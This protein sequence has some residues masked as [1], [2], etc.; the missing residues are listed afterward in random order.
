MLALTF[1]GLKSIYAFGSLS[2][3]AEKIHSA[4]GVT[5]WTESLPLSEQHQT[6]HLLKHSRFLPLFNRWWR[7]K[8]SMLTLAQ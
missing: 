4:E 3:L 6:H 8:P 2:T 7:F 5:V 1:Q